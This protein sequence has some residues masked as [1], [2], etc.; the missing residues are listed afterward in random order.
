MLTALLAGV[1]ALKHAFGSCSW[2][3]FHLSPYVSAL[4]C[5]VVAA[6]FIHLYFSPLPNPTV[7]MTMNDIIDFESIPAKNHIVLHTAESRE[8][9][10]SIPPELYPNVQYAQQEPMLVASNTLFTQLWGKKELA[11]SNTPSPRKLEETLKIA[12]VVPKKVQVPLIDGVEHKLQKGENLWELANAYGVSFNKIL[13]YNQNLNT[14][15]MQPGDQVFIP[16]AKDPLPPKS[17][18][19]ILPLAKLKYVSSRYGY[20]THPLGGHVRF[21][22]GVD[23]SARSGTAVRAVLDGKVIYSGRKGQLGY[24]VEIQH[25]NGLKTVYGHNRRLKVKAG[26]RVRQGSIIAEVGNTGRSTAPHLHFEVWKDDKH[27]NP[28]DFLPKNLKFKHERV[29]KN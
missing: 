24:T 10:Y 13:Y 3:S 8:V 22:R 19:M 27:R 6:L 29:V 25:D 1:Y 11:K 18:Q 16:G 7:K 21:H 28:V 2:R 15:R 26:Q 20:R 17:N 14:R 4:G 12:K 9:N 23:M 5:G